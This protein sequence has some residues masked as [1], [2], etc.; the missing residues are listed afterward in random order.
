MSKKYVIR[1]TE[2]ERVGLTGLVN[3]GKVAAGKR[4]HAEI[5]LKADAGPNGKIEGRGT[6]KIDPALKPDPERGEKLYKTECGAC[7]GEDGGGAKNARGE[8]MFPP[9]WGDASFNI[10]AGIARTNT[11]AGFVKANMP[12]AHVSNFPQNQGGLSD[13][14]ALDIAEY[15]SHQ[16]RPDFPEKINDWPKGGKPADARY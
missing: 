1:L 11:A 8:R 12:I 7:H 6:A 15:F 5:L 16:P 10:G 14:D 3:T 9:L 13:Q 4:R 2:G